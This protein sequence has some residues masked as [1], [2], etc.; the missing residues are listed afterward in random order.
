MRCVGIRERRHCASGAVKA[1]KE[2]ILCT[3]L[4][5]LPARARAA[6]PHYHRWERRS[7]S[8]TRSSIV[9]VVSRKKTIDLFNTI[10]TTYINTNI[11]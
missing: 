11:H 6:S 9:R 8:K 4:L 5:A 3:W 1:N 10:T 7:K 2:I